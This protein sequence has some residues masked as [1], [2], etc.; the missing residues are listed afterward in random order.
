MLVLH[1]LKSPGDLLQTDVQMGSVTRYP[2]DEV[3]NPQAK[4][5]EA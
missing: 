2:K 5:L 4:S 3:T 1:C